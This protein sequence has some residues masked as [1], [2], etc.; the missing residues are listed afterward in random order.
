M[1][2]LWEFFPKSVSQN[3]PQVFVNIAH[4]NTEWYQPF[5]PLAMLVCRPGLGWAPLF[6]AGLVQGVEGAEEGL[7]FL[8]H[9]EVGGVPVGENIVLNGSHLLTMS[10]NTNEAFLFTII[11]EI[12]LYL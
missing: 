3:D 9:G 1:W 6:A 8:I 7:L 12:S 11:S 10:D 4:Q 2:E 5:F